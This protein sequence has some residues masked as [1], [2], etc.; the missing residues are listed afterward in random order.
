MRRDL[1]INSMFY[2]INLGTVED[3]SGYGL[4]DLSERIARTPLDPLT[5]FTDDPLRV[6]RTIRFAARFQLSILPEVQEALVE[7]SVVLALLNKISRER[8]A[9]EFFLMIKGK[10]H[11]QALMHLKE[12]KMFEVIF[13]IPQEFPDLLDV[14]FRLVSRIQRAKSD[15][16]LFFYVAGM[17]FGYA[18]GEEYKI[19]NKKKD[20]KLYEYIC[21]ENLK[22][23]NHE[24]AA[25]CSILNNIEKCLT[26][27]SNFDVLIIAEIIR[28]TKDKWEICVTLASFHYHQ[29]NNVAEEAI[30]RIGEQVRAHEI[31]SVWDEKPLLNVLYI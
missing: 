20:V 23:S 5:T 11:M 13:K 1:T 4:K 3:F 19:L 27:F 25:I 30:L 2:N 28:E 15:E 31:E 18:V 6:L 12:F 7:P 24:I 26:L 21:T 16:N 22:M 14:G 10:N 9:K 29:E 8:I 17:L